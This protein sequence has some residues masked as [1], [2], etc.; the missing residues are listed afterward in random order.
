MQ[1]HKEMRRQYYHNY[2][3]DA[4]PHKLHYGY[5]TLRGETS[6]EKQASKGV[7][8]SVLVRPIHAPISAHWIW[9]FSPYFHP[10]TCLPFAIVLLQ[11][12]GS[13]W[14]GIDST[15]LVLPEA[16]IITL[17]AKN[18]IK[19]AFLK[20]WCC[21]LKRRVAFDITF[22]LPVITSCVFCKQNNKDHSD[23]MLMSKRV[24]WDL[25]G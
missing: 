11:P 17:T 20:I 23:N 10:H 5:H 7:P 16:T 13:Q 25:L 4:P 14:P 8:V 2:V 22:S 21:S 3:Y 9:L 15:L 24:C 19:S 12:R 1:E 18:N 6:P